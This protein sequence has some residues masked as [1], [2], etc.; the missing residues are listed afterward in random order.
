MRINLI[1]FIQTGRTKN[2]GWNVGYVETKNNKW[3]FAMNMDI[4]NKQDAKYR[5]IITDEIL[6]YEKIIE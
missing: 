4:I 5:K 3:V 6:K 1:Q 2:I